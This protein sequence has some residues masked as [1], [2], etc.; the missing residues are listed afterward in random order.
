MEPLQG[1]ATSNTWSSL[2]V[3]RYSYLPSI[4][5]FEVLTVGLDCRTMCN[6]KRVADN[7]RL[8]A[9]IALGA[10]ASVTA[11]TGRKQASAVPEY[12]AAPR[13]VEGNPIFHL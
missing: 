9:R 7:P 8:S 5:G 3:E 1:A 6:E 12:G 4:L 13:L 11:A 10:L 2:T